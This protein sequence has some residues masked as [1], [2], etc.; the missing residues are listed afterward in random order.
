MVGKITGSF[1]TKIKLQPVLKLDRP[2]LNN[3]GFLTSRNFRPRKPAT[4]RA[5]RKMQ[6]QK[7]RRNFEDLDVDRRKI[8]QGMLEKWN[9]VKC[10]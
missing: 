8:L 2:D 4:G 1:D 7:R 3:L 6:L 9:G 5:F 10:V